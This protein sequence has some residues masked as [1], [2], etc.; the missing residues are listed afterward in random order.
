MIFDVSYWMVDSITLIVRK[1]PA[2]AIDI[3][4]VR[5]LYI[6]DSIFDHLNLKAWSTYC[7]AHGRLAT[8]GD[9]MI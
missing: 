9:I 6:Y 2:K 4:L 3:F 1:I 8:K 7:S 5:L